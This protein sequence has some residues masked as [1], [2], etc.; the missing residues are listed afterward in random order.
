MNE[1]PAD[2]TTT[3]K[4]KSSI[5]ITKLPINLNESSSS[6]S[7][8]NN[9]NSSEKTLAQMSISN[10]KRS[11]NLPPKIPPLKFQ[12]YKAYDV[13]LDCYIEDEEE[14][15]N[16]QQL[17]ASFRGAK[18]PK[19]F[20]DFTNKNKYAALNRSNDEPKKIKTDYSCNKMR[21]I[22]NKYF[23]DESQT[24]SKFVL[25]VFFFLFFKDTIHLHNN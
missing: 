6:S 12:D 2:T 11:L 10:E 5:T 21:E 3:T 18:N 20:G 25:F 19:L 24:K 22:V 14:Y 8:S 4:K 23:N 13:D 1:T 17:H 9:N 7:S 15:N 16:Q